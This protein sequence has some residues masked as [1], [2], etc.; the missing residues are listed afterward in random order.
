VRTFLLFFVVWR[1][2]C[3]PSTYPLSFACCSPAPPHPHPNHSTT[4]RPHSIATALIIMQSASCVTLRH[5]R[6]CHHRHCQ[7]LPPSALFAEHAR[8]ELRFRA[9]RIAPVAPPARSR[10]IARR[11]GRYAHQQTPSGITAWACRS[12]AL[13]AAQV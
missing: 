11:T 13:A 3:S 2:C 9:A 4:H 1:C 5:H 7:S 8:F 6:H 12:T 10:F